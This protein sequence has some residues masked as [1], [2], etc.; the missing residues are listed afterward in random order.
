MIPLSFAQRRLWFQQRMEGASATYNISGALRLWGRLD[1]GALES[2]FGDV[3]GRHE[4]LRTVF[5]EVDGEPF[6]DVL[7]LDD[8][9]PGFEVVA[10]PGELAAALSRAAAHEFDLGASTPPI[11]VVVFVVG[12]EEH[13]LLLTVHHIAADGWSIAPLLRDLGVAF[14]ARCAGAE[15]DWE[16]LPV[17]YV[18]YTLWQ[19]EL[20][21]DADDPGSLLAEQLAYWTKELAGLPECLELPTDRP[22]P[23]IA[24]YV[25]A[26]LTVH[27]EPELHA[28]IANLAA[29]QGATT[30]MVLH[31]AIAMLLSK[32]G[33]GPDIP[34]GS[35]IAGRTDEALDDLVGFFVN[36]L[37]LRA[38]LSGD[39]TF[40]DLL[41]Q[42]RDTDLTAFANQDVPFERIVEQLNPRRS[43]AYNPLFQVM[44]ALQNTQRAAALL[45]GLDV[46]VEPVGVATAKVDLT[47]ALAESFTA[48]RPAG[49]QCEIQYA[50]DLFDRETVELIGQRLI[51][52]LDA[53]T[54][55]P[56]RKL[57]TIDIILPGERQ[58]LAMTTQ[59]TGTM[60]HWLQCQA[61]Q[62]PDAR[63]LVC[64]N[65]TLT[66]GALADRVNRLA[67]L[68]ISQGIGQEDRVALLLPRSL[69][70]VTAL[71][72][73]MTAGAAYV[74]I[75]PEYPADRIAYLLTDT[76]P[77]LLL[78]TTRLIP[79]TPTHA[80]TLDTV[81]LTAHDPHP[82]TDADRRAPL[83]QQDAAY[84]IHTS[85]STGQPK[86]VAVC[87]DNL[88][89]LRAHHLTETIPGAQ[90]AAFTA[91]LSFDAS[92]DGLLLLTSGVELHLL[93]DEVRRDAQA[94]V[95]YLRANQVDLLGTTPSYAEELL[96]AGLLDGDVRPTRVIVGG[97]PVSPAL[98]DRLA[99]VDA[100]NFYGPTECTV[101]T[102][103]AR[104]ADNSRPVIGTPVRGTQAHV[105]DSWL[106]PVPLGVA[107]ELYLAGTPVARGYHGKPGLTAERFV[108]D[109]FA[110][111]TRMYRTG[112]RARWR[113]DGLLE[114]LGRTDDQVK[115][116]GFRIEPGEV[117]A[118]L[119]RDPA[120]D[121]AAVTVKDGKLIGY[122]VP[123][124]G[125]VDLPALRSS[126]AD[127]LPSHMVPSALV[128][129]AQLPLTP[130]GKLDH[131]ALPAPEHSATGRAPRTEREE[132]LCGLFA[133]V[134]GVASV[135]V[136][137]NFF[138]LGGHSLLATRLI[139]RVR[140]TLG[141]ELPVRTLFQAPTP[142]ELALAL[143]RE[144]AAR[145]PLEPQDRPEVIP[146]SFAQ[147]R[148]WFLTRLEGPSATYNI[149]GAV[150]LRGHLD[151]NALRAAVSDVV[152]RHETL[153][154]VFVADAGV[155]SQ[156]VLDDPAPDFRVV[157][158]APDAAAEQIR[159]HAAEVFDLA[160]SPL[161][162]VVLAIGPDEHV[163]LVVVHHI[164]ADGWSIAPLL[165]DLTMAYRARLGGGS[166]DWVPLPVQYVDYTLWQRQNLDEAKQTRFWSETL[167]G[168]PDCLVLPVDRQRPAVS[169]YRGGNVAT[170]IDADLH[171]RVVSL[172]RASG[173]T[174]FMVL[175]AA[176]ATLLTKM[177]AGTDL[178]IGSPVAG[179][180]DS[181]LDDLVGFFVNT[182]VLRA[183]LSGDPAFSEALARV[184]DTDLAAYANQDLPFERVVEQLNPRRSPAYNPLF[185]VL[186]V[187]QNTPAT[188]G[189]LPGLE[190][191]V[192]PVGIA[193]AKVDLTFALAETYCTDGAPAGIRLDL[194]YAL[195]LFDP[196]TAEALTRR[197]IRVL[198]QVTAAPTAK[199]SEVDVAEPGEGTVVSPQ[200]IPVSETL[201]DLFAAQVAARP[202]SIALVCGADRVTYGELGARVDQIAQAVIASGAGPEDLVALLL[203]RSVDQVAALLGVV[204]AGAA[205]VPIDPTYP[206]ERI[207]Y[208]LD[209]SQ[210]ALLITDRPQPWP[211]TTIVLDDL[212]TSTERR[213]R[214]ELTP[215]HPAYVIYTSGSTGNPKG[216]VVTHRNVVRLLD[217]T[218]HWFGFTPDDVWTLF[219]SYAFDFSVWELWGALRYGGTLVVV[220]FDVSRDPAAFLR[221]LTDERVTVLNQTPSAFYQLIAADTGSE[222]DLR[223]VVF[224]G[225]ALEPALLS[226]WQ[227]CRPDGPALVNMYGITETTVHVTHLRLDGEHV[228]SPIGQPIP[229]LGVY[230]LDSSLRPTPTG[231]IGELYVT[232]GGLARGY[233]N[234]PRLTAQRFVACPFER[235]ER[236]YR[237]G[238]A[239]VRTRDGGLRY[240]GRLDQQVKIRGFR[241]ELG[242]VEAA[243]ATH[244]DVRQVAVIHRDDRLV[245]Y[246]VSDTDAAALRQHVSG[247]LPDHMMPVFVPIPALPLTTNG[248]LDQRALPEP[249]RT[250]S[251]QVPRSPRE[252]VLCGLF[253]EVLG[254]E[255]VGIDDNFFALG[256]H[257]LLAAKLIGRIR[258]TLGIDVPMRA[259]FQAPTVLGLVSA[260]TSAT[261]DPLVT[262]R[263]DGD[264]RPLFC[265]HPISGVAWCYSALQRHLPAD[266]PIHGL[267]VDLASHPT[268]LDELT[269]GYLRHIRGVQPEGPYRLLG[270]SLG[271][272]IAHAVAARLRSEGAE[273]ELLALL[274]SFPA[275][276]AAMPEVERAL[277]ITMAR[278]LGLDENADNLRAAVAA[279][280]GLP[281][282]TLTQLAAST[283]NL[284][285]VLLNTPTTVFDGDVLYVTA[286]RSATTRGSGAHLWDPFTRQITEH[287]V[288]CGHFDM[289][290]PE[291][292]ARIGQLVTAQ[293]K[294][295]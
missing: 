94:L 173:A 284:G 280:F 182:L 194:Q 203:P 65:A 59:A 46:E 193:T 141:T 234:Q 217:A 199:L 79:A 107:G 253:A 232:G 255:S 246:V 35:P 49:I 248:K 181:A 29:A 28:R 90:R 189:T 126:V 161:R 288:D 266:V 148:L 268:T 118:A 244:P 169:S 81:D 157:D 165:T 7:A 84:V 44:L 170:T 55:N 76:A 146:L 66:Y 53:V 166:P 80:I 27:I 261:I 85:G 64:G 233:L 24:T 152:T 132:I 271:G 39:P 140:T 43:P 20:L 111:G 177:G 8:V 138:D 249:E 99:E 121:R 119:T 187:L 213:V 4:A 252:D 158:C 228:G 242:E 22:R 131:R 33:A 237:T 98:W 120:V 235:G 96:V 1:V 204:M 3:L 180:V 38:D 149:P 133:T 175:H 88:A 82:L 263:A 178:P 70:L 36:T 52:L 167:A 270:W 9:T 200:P 256:G 69:D 281:E 277:L 208:V 156:V 264:Q 136:D 100:I 260:E 231:V 293:L 275:Q 102:A 21:G 172:A 14:A 23:S 223:Y 109:P 127:A 164:A 73:V 25:G 48:G 262:I 58:P 143:D 153:R 214:P 151:L 13:V 171:A 276:G 239:A 71:F 195:D 205:Y 206:D 61:A 101:N 267:Q 47:F 30:F 6:Q 86:G 34:I 78:T 265:F 201:A 202:D 62:T 42:V 159:A 117:A 144:S 142:A 221:L 145:P 243:I 274:D 174:V 57:S 212:P 160:V 184:R 40:A 12:P 26:D 197:L 183:D 258:E 16:P 108:A 113:R 150:R 123:A 122:V 92:L 87:H 67:R 147:Q 295:R 104:I 222:L 259:L 240:I 278:D 292:I 285:R 155:P 10:A 89:N 176:L 229:D 286:A 68:L 95:A 74:P 128:E 54:T 5:G 18:D 106:Q 114:Y 2:A 112:D 272:T 225:E 218:D 227:E 97:E 45:P 238:D 192:E 294:D 110:H 241:I 279:G 83:R 75:D 37:V 282:E 186:L 93:T 134:L 154:T 135:G 254:I 207:R 56:S 15:P 32:L 209:D 250:A 188:T 31:A 163:L 129:L 224:G 190:A 91:S 130:N 116:R 215:D 125:S 211:V 63:A 51:R 179:R 269:S 105:L 77:K 103:T 226:R 17:Q 198:D 137:D 168:A 247:L 139:S 115:V 191:V 287:P 230:V 283:E 72:A 216:V 273:V 41:T 210:P 291:P 245:A 19:R 220:P 196:Q 162:V 251:G 50:V 257:S 219:H 236:M 11:R 289:M 185:Q 124:H 290:R 60:P